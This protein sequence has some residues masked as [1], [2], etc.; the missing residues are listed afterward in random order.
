MFRKWIFTCMFLLGL[1]TATAQDGLDTLYQQRVADYMPLYN[2]TM[3]PGYNKSFMNDPYYPKVY[4]QGS[5]TYLGWEYKG[6]EMLIDTYRQRLIVLSNDRK[7]RI[8]VPHE[9]IAKLEIGGTEYEW[10]DRDDHAP[11]TGYYAVIYKGKETIYRLRY[12]HDPEKRIE[13][14]QVLAEFVEREKLYLMRDGKWHELSGRSSYLKLHKDQK[15]ALQRYCKEQRL[16][17]ESDEDWRQLASYYE[18]LTR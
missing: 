1:Q 11:Q 10:N 5:V 12:T 15:A 16:Q 4:T 18:N 3:E 14:R 9:G 6:V 13:N 8:E 17:L 2:G 7:R